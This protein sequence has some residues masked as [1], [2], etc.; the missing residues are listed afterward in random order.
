[1][2]F[3]YLIKMGW[4]KNRI[5]SEYRKHGNSEALDWSA[6]AE[7]K[8]ESEIRHLI[9]TPMCRAAVCNPILDAKCQASQ[10]ERQRILKA[11]GLNDELW[12]MEIKIDESLK[13]NEIKLI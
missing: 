7:K 6:I 5:D 11:L 12:G 13:P 9:N 10:K 2:G 8:I 4:I 3:F 1:M